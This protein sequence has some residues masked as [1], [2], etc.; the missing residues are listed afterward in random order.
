MMEGYLGRPLATAEALRDGWLNTGDLGF[1]V[2]GELYITSRCKDV[3][4]L[5]GRNHS[6]VE[7]EH[8]VNE[9]EGVRTGCAAAA[10]YMPE[11]AAGEVLIVFVEAAGETSE[12][13]YPSIADAVARVV[14]A[15][16]GLDPDHV[17]VVAPGTLPRTSSGKI[18]RLEALRQWLGGELAPPA[19]VT[20]IRLAGAVLRS[21]LAMARS[22]RSRGG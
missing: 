16:S 21:S 4:I 15:A 19:P 5:R 13:R 10:S 6:P 2:G 17:E 7:V 14:R 3:L 22:R 20:P 1:I 9:V 18:R 12:A 8:A 11:G